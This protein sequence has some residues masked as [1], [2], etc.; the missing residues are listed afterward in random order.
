MV[1]D[2]QAP[3]SLHFR[4]FWSNSLSHLPFLS[5]EIF[6]IHPAA[7]IFLSFAFL[8][9]TARVGWRFTLQLRPNGEVSRA[10]AAASGHLP[11][12]LVGDCRG[13]NHFFRFLAFLPTSLLCCPQRSH[14]AAAVCTLRLDK[15]YGET[16]REF[17]R[18]RSA[19]SERVYCYTCYCIYLIKKR[20]TIGAQ[21][22]T[23][24]LWEW[25][26]LQVPH[27]RSIGTVQYAI[28]NLTQVFWIKH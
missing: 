16:F 21:V 2:N 5:F 23:F 28:S 13:I 8:H 20:R 9:P 24:F 10:H 19:C 25:N 6:N 15:S 26:L 17:L 12:A 3:H 1:C 7:I 22:L 27:V 18:S 11:T 14:V 4:N